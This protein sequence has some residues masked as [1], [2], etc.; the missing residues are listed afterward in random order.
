[1]CLL[2]T[3][4][5][6]GT[7]RMQAAHGQP[8][9]CFSAD[10]TLASKL[11]ALLRI[12]KGHMEFSHYP[13][14]DCW[15]IWKHLIHLKQQNKNWA[16]IT[17]LKLDGA[18]E[19]KCRWIFFSFLPTEKLSYLNATGV[20][21]SRKEKRFVFFLSCRKGDTHGLTVNSKKEP[22]KDFPLLPQLI[23]GD[24]VPGKYTHT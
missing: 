13:Q 22:F 6:T 12:C 21:V 2:S 19:N 11:A 10:S 16:V 20:M 9:R 23:S 8:R 17:C 7:G 14:R 15:S 18:H 5:R 4:L 24:S 1:M 3:S